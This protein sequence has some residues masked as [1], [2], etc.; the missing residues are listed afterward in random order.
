MRTHKMKRILAVTAVAAAEYVTYVPGSLPIILSA[1]HGGSERPASIP[2]R[3]SGCW[4]GGS[5][6]FRPDC[7][8]RDADRCGVSTISDMNTNTMTAELSDAFFAYY[9]AR[10]NCVYNNLHRSK[11]DANRDL[12]EA[13]QTNAEAVHA[14]HQFQGYIVEA[15]TDVA[16]RHG[17]GLYVDVHGQVA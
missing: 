1:P 11:L 4:I 15:A 3:Q 12:P 14:W 13:A 10:P 17:Y 6:Q 9:G 5:C 8:P 2:N 16:N 7:S